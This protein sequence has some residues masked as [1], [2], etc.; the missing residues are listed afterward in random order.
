MH[1][2]PLLCW[3]SVRWAS[4]RMQYTGHEV[5]GAGC[6]TEDMAM[7]LRTYSR[8]I[9][10]NFLKKSLTASVSRWSAVNIDNAAASWPG[11]PFLTTNLG[12]PDP[13][14][15]IRAKPLFFFFGSSTEGATE[16]LFFFGSAVGVATLLPHPMVSPKR[17][18]GGVIEESYGK[19]A[20]CMEWNC[21]FRRF[22]KMACNWAAWRMVTLHQT[23]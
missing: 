21:C 22:E 19:K 13:T 12:P 1:S 16:F 8:S 15:I 6:G 20:Y 7:P 3:H 4:V 18:H 11:T 2:R 14:E 10:L 17:G 5:C 9:S 23:A